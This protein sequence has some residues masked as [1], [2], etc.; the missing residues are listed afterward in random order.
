MYN[1]PEPGEPGGS[2]RL[3]RDLSELENTEEGGEA[4]EDH[5]RLHQDEPIDINEFLIHLLLRGCCSF[6]FLMHFCFIN[7]ASV[8]NH[9][10]DTRFELCT[11]AI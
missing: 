11:V 4:Q 10:Q 3:V 5:H 8:F 6:W 9:S 1:A 7:M 2:E